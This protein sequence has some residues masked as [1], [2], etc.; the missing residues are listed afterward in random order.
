M[1]H[2]LKPVEIKRSE[3]AL[4][5]S[6]SDGSK[7]K[8]HSERLRKA[9]PCAECRESRGESFHSKPIAARKASPS[10]L[11]VVEATH[12]EATHLEQIW[13]VGNYAIGT[14]WGDGHSTGIYPYT[15]LIEL[16]ESAVE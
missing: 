13:P 4:F 8:L 7:S 2:V 16:A 6:W 3:D 10:M 12:D 11:Q 14:R 5:I 15:L 9:C 1:R